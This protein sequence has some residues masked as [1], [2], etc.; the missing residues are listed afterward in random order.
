MSYDYSGNA[1]IQR[2]KFLLAE[3]C[4][5]ENCRQYQGAAMVGHDLSRHM[6]VFSSEL[7]REKFIFCV[8]AYMRIPVY[9][10]RPRT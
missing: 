3:V 8:G 6:S 7:C 5:I 1:E 4:N 9:P 2:L 10:C